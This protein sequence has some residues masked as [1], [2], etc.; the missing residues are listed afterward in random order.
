MPLKTEQRMLLKSLYQRLDDKALKPGDEFYEPIYDPEGCEDPVALMRQHIEWSNTESIQ[1]FSGFRGSGKTT[2]LF[3]LQK[4]LEEK[5][6]FVLY[7]DALKY[8]NPAQ[9]IDITDL[10]IVLA[11][12]FSDAL[13]KAGVASLG[14]DSYW[15]RLKNY[16]VTTKVE[17]GEIG[18]QAGA[19]LKLNLETSP[20]F[21]QLLRQKLANRIGEIKRDVAVSSRMES[22]PSRPSM[23]PK[24]PAS[25]FCSTRWSKYEA[26]FPTNN[27]SLI[28][29]RGFS[30]S[31]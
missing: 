30:P 14:H 7:G 18:L 21:R 9:E 2:E 31:T 1:M 15:E 23:A 27:Q 8:L 26:R 24:F 4:G 20:T 25:S 22:R 5:G 19:D 12:T 3:R 16:L 17:L 11:G 6:Y 13:E 10:L 28:A 29:W